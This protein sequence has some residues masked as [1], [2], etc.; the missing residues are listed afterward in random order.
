MTS[1]VSKLDAI[2]SRLQINKSH[3]FQDGLATLWEK[4]NKKD[5][6]NDQYSFYKLFKKFCHL[7]VIKYKD[8]QYDN[9]LE[10]VDV[11]ND[12]LWNKCVLS[13]KLFP[14][15]L[16]LYSSKALVQLK[17]DLTTTFEKKINKSTDFLA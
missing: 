11:A 2:Y 8:F 15:S 17:K 14:K 16:I 3:L 13:G 1:N 6:Q 7:F 9:A 10:S 4:I 12:D 5:S